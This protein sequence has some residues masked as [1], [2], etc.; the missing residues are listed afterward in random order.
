M[1]LIT[2]GGNVLMEM[3]FRI[4]DGG[5][6]EMLIHDPLEQKDLFKAVAIEDLTKSI[7][8]VFAEEGALDKKNLLIVDENLIAINKYC[9]VT[10]QPEHKRIVTY[11][12]KAYNINFPNSIYIICHNSDKITQIEAFC[13]KEYQ[14]L[15]TELMQYAMPNM[16]HD[17]AICIGSAPRDI[18]P[19]KYAEALERI[20]FTQYTH[21]QFSGVKSFKDTKTYFEYLE[22][23]EYPYHLLMPLNK[24]LSDIL[25]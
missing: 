21:S 1:L 19:L 8:E 16:L 24:K 5:D 3:I 22:K 11:K 15:K 18:D 12:E 14:G 17:N 25:K 20:I 2:Q 23:N 10:K 13:Y 9:I 6:A 7:Q 4:L